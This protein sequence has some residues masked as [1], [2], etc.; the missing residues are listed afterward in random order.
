MWSRHR[1]LW[2]GEQPSKDYQRKFVERRLEFFPTTIFECHERISTSLGVVFFAP[3]EEEFAKIEKVLL[4]LALAHGLKV[5]VISEFDT[6]FAW[7]QRLSEQPWHHNAEKRVKVLARNLQDD[8]DELP[9]D[10]ARF[11]IGPQQSPRVQI[12]GGSTLREEDL[13]LL[14]RAFSDCTQV[15]LQKMTTGTALVF[16]AFARLENSRI[17]PYPLPLFVKLHKKRK[18]ARELKN[19][20]DSTT[21][22]IPFNARPNLGFD[23]CLLGAE[24]GLIVGDFV[25][26]SD[27]LAELVR[28]G[29]AGLAVNSLFENALRGWRSQAYLQPGAIVVGPLLQDGAIRSW[30]E[31]AQQQAESYAVEAKK[32]GALDTAAAIGA[33]LDQ[34][35][36]IRHRRGTIHGDLHGENV[37]VRASEAI[38]IDFA[39]VEDF[40]ALVMD[41]AALETSLVLKCT[42]SASHPFDETDWIELVRALYSLENLVKLPDVRAPT[43]PMNELW[44]VVRQI[45]RFGYSDQLTDLEYARAVAIQLLRH[46]LRRRDDNEPRQRRPMFICLAGALAKALTKL[47][48]PVPLAA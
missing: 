1:V 6:V 10:F 12:E 28:R 33:L 5:V 19:Y 35:P 22:F 13:V 34:L 7:K 30:D 41:P 20:R 9:E 48:S 39:A 11:E 8:V 17:G 16:Q 23:R 38:L 15:R 26:H 47:A 25:E 27:S 32:Q 45:R 43:A 44:N 37:R 18:I 3:T 46:A 29:T 42:A 21:H 4:A 2:V 24:R 14:R 40:G 31:R 36:N